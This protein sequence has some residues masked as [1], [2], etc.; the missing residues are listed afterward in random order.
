M[1]TTSLVTWHRSPSNLCRR[2]SSRVNAL[3]WRAKMAMQPILPIAV[4]VNKIKGA[5]CQH[6]SD[7]DKVVRC[8]QALRVIR[9]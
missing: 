3:R 4:P 6:Y 8:E 7:G 2:R 9:V 1:W 5:S